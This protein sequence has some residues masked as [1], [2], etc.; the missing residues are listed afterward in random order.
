MGTF[1]DW[2][3]VDNDDVDKKFATTCYL[4]S[5]DF[6]IGDPYRWVA[7]NTKNSHFIH[8]KNGKTYGVGN[9]IICEACDWGSKEDKVQRFVDMYIELYTK[10]W[11]AVEE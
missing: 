10:F 1:E 7:S 3:K 4:C 8:P 9:F 11:W 6:K 2:R 5:Y